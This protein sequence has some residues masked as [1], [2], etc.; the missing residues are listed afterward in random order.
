MEGV[1]AQPRAFS[2]Q[3]PQGGWIIQYL[4]F[5][6]KT[7]SESQRTVTLSSRGLEALSS[8]LELVPW[9][10]KGRG[11]SWVRDSQVPRMLL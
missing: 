4:R 2:G 10:P 5:P 8:I 1:E 3:S 11:G 9:P 7:R 6:M